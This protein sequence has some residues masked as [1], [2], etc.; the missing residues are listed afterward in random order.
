MKIGID[1]RMLGSG[2]G[3]A[4]YIQQL[5]RQLEKIDQHNQYIL[6][7]RREN[8]EEF[9]PR[10]PN[11]EKILADIPW[12]SWAEQIKFPALIRK[13]KLDLM[14]FPHW[15]VPLLYS[16]RFVVTIHDLTMYH[17]PRAEATTLGPLAYRVKDRL[18]RLVIRNAV[19][20]ADKII[21]TSEFTKKD[22]QKTLGVAEEKMIITYQAP[23]VGS[24]PLERT[25]LVS[26]FEQLGVNREYVLYVGA[27]YPHKNLDNLIQAWKIFTE[28]YP[29]DYQL[30][31]VGREN[32]FYRQLFRHVRESNCKNIIFTG[33]MPDD[34][35]EILYAGASLFIFPS[36]YEGFGLPP[37]EA[38]ARQVP[39]AASDRACL[40]ETLGDA[41]YYFN[42]E[43]PREIAEA[44]Q[45][46]M[47]DKNLRQRLIEKGK[48]IS[49]RH[50]W[51]ELALTTKQIYQSVDK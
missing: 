16:G 13:Q 43:K 37:L 28:Q 36:L 23:F 40:P 44:M 38:M 25:G 29:D 35:L 15:N 14:H 27:A 12:Y 42:P 17:Y 33:F 31:L 22:V 30:V 45:H 5:T 51:R 39:V 18:H 32:F 8:W 3:L 9:Q 47:V 11:F 1:A 7:M 41:A 10:Q 21:V 26:F 4:R 34:K 24:A 48:D 19:K 2:F 6:F 46:L 50:S 49:S 20:T